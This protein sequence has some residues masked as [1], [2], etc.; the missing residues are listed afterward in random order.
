MDAAPGYIAVFAH[1][2]FNFVSLKAVNFEEEKKGEK[3][4]FCEVQQE[5]RLEI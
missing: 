2:S 3:Q 5:G 1:T 4:Q